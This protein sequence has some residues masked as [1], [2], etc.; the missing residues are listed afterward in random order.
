MR[1]H[2]LTAGD[3]LQDGADRAAVAALVFG[4]LVR[5]GKRDQPLAAAENAPNRRLI[6]CLNHARYFATA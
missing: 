4:P 5:H 1:V 6:F 3:A 2:A